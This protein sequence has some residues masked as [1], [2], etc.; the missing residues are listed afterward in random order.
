[1]SSITLRILS[2]TLLLTVAGWAPAQ[3]PPPPA[4]EAPIVT[5]IEIQYVGPATISRDRILA[6]MR[7][8]IGQPFS[9]A[10][11]QEDIRT[12]FGTGEITNVR[13]FGEEDDEGV[14]VVVVV[15]TRAEISEVILNGAEA[16]RPARLRRDIGLEPGQPLDEA[17]V[18][19]ARQSMLELYQRRGFAQA[20]IEYVVDVDEERGTARVVFDINEGLRATIKDISFE[21]NTVFT[22]REL[23]GVM[24]T[25]TANLLSF[26]TSAG[27]L[28]DDVLEDD[29][30]RL[31][32][33]YQNAGYVDAEITEI[34]FQ[35]IDDKRIAITIFIDEG[36]QYR[37]G[38]VTFSG[39]RVFTEQEL[40]D[41][42]QILEGS[43]YSPAGVRRD[44]QAIRDLYGTDGYVDLLIIPERLPGEPLEININY[45]LDEGIQ[46]YVERVNIEGNIRTKDKV[47]RRELA[48]VPGEVYD[49]VRV[50][51][52]RQRLMNLG[53][54]SQVESFPS[55]TLVPGRKDLNVIVEEQRTGSFNFGAGFSS[56]DNLVGFAELQQSNFD[57]ANWPSFIGGGQRFRT[58]VQFGTRR[59]DF[60]VSLTEPW[61]LDYQ[62]SLGGEAYY[63]EAFFLSD[64]YDQSNL[65][66]ALLGRTPLN[67]FTSLDI[68]Y[69]LEQV[70]IFDVDRN[71]SEEIQSQAGSKVQSTLTAGV[72][73]DSRDSVFLTRR[74]QRVNFQTYVAGGPLGFD[75]QIYGMDLS[76]SQYFSL[77]WDT[78]FQI[79]GQVAV[80]D[81]W[82]GG[83]EVPIFSRLYLGGANNLRGFRFREVGPKDDQGEPIGGQSL[84][85]LTLEYTFPII[86]RV[87]G[88][89]FYDAGFVNAGAYDFGFGNINSDIGLGVRLDLPI[90]PIRLDFGI[91]IQS[92]EFNDS[93]GRFNFNVGYQF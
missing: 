32:D 48:V 31:R 43:V 62:F 83:D 2:L 71:A 51:A 9:P 17:E 61:F 72:L 4:Q 91:P 52:S 68:E 64:V 14:V 6:N 34:D 56:I 10:T 19:A 8:S 60:I 15:Q 33:H 40:R 57:V 12:L 63:R 46:S 21:G 23:R 50:E 67:E 79:V 30:V 5:D 54:F 84:A 1:M 45:A 76:A 16:I 3:L 58:R 78:I 11:V 89:V 70:R 86:S 66:F 69:R 82:G 22:D 49:T 74:G 44:I 39:E 65:G 38:T 29:L 77:P 88:A 80:V 55:D 37:A 35:R 85:R 59:R 92:D 41:R 93:S 75:V 13:I 27:R 18:E 47:I 42:M 20:T 25:S 73:Y 81:S 26:I 90:G 7:T 24:Q 87:R 53:Y 28:E 36:E